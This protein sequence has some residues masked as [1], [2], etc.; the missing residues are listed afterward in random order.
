[1]PSWEFVVISVC[2]TELEPGW[3]EPPLSSVALCRRPQVLR[4]HMLPYKT[5][6]CGKVPS[7]NFPH[8][9]TLSAWLLLRSRHWEPHGAAAQMVRGTG[10]RALFGQAVEASRLIDPLDNEDAANTGRGEANT[11]DQAWLREGW[12]GGGA[13]VPGQWEGQLS[14]DVS[15]QC[16]S[17][18]TRN[19]YINSLLYNHDKQKSIHTKK[20]KFQIINSTSV[21][22]NSFFPPAT[23][24][25]KLHSVKG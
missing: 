9:F 5:D 18:R 25:T 2:P 16:R 10:K 1:M 6:P 22:D 11:G 4:Q 13:Q 15:G 19:I 3:A 14:R 21:S 23:Q 24:S 8:P 20:Y 12:K 17:R 7:A